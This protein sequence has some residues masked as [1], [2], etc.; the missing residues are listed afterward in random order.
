M[1]LVER[2]IDWVIPFPSAAE[3]AVPCLLSMEAVPYDY[4][5]I[6]GPMIHGDRAHRL[7]HLFLAI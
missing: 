3:E 2:Q 7:L 1:L 4:Q 6:L 5:A